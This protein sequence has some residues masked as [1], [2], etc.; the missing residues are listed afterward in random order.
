MMMIGESV[1]Q[2]IRHQAIDPAGYQVLDQ[3]CNQ[4]RDRVW[5]QVK[6]QVWSQVWLLVLSQLISQA[7]ALRARAEER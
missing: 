6:P 1:S 2:R 7:R 4:V 5:W 3:V